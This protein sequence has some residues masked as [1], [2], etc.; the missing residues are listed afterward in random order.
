MAAPRDGAVPRPS[1]QRASDSQHRISL[2]SADAI[3]Q[4]SLPGAKPVAPSWHPHAPDELKVKDPSSSVLLPHLALQAEAWA[5]R[6]EESSASSSP[7]SP[8]ASQQIQA[9]RVLQAET[10]KLQRPSIKVRIITWNQG[11]S[12][13]KGDLGVLLGKVGEYISPEPDWDVS[14]DDGDEEAK[15]SGSADGK[16]AGSDAQSTPVSDRQGKQK[17]AIPPTQD[18]PQHK[19]R[20]R[21]MGI[22]GQE[23]VPRKD[24]IPPLPHDDAHPYHV[25][26]IAGQECPWG[27]GKRISTGM[28][29]AGE[30]GDLGR[31]K[32]RAAALAKEREKASKEGIGGGGGGAKKDDKEEQLAKEIDMADE[33]SQPHEK[34][35]PDVKTA[36]KDKAAEFPFG[37]PPSSTGLPLA[38]PGGT[39]AVAGAGWARNTRGW[40]DMCEDWLCRGPLAQATATKGMAIASTMNGPNASPLSPAL[41]DGNSPWPSR[42]PSPS[43]ISGVPSSETHSIISPGPLNASSP[44]KR[45]SLAVPRKMI[46]SISRQ[47]LDSDQRR[48]PSTVN[49]VDE[50]DP[51]DDSSALSLS[52]S[53]TDRFFTPFGQSLDAAMSGD[54]ARPQAPAVPVAPADVSSTTT[55]TP[56]ATQSPRK[57]HHRLALRIPGLS[58]SHQVTVQSDGTP[59][60]LGA[61]ELVTK[62]RCYMMYTA[63]YV[64]RG[65]LDRVRGV[66]N[67]HVKSGLLSGRV[68]NKGAVGISLKL[69]Q[70]RLLFVNAHLAAHEGRIAERIANV[71]KIKRELKVDTFLP[72]DDPRNEDN[73]LTA[74]F[75][76]A[77]WFGDLNF[78]VDISRKHADWLMMQKRYDH[79]LAF[80]QL[81]MIMKEQ[82]TVFPAFLEAP[83]TFPPTFKYDVL[84]T[85]KIKR[86]QEKRRQESTRKDETLLSSS[87]SRGNISVPAGAIPGDS[88]QALSDVDDDSSSVSSLSHIVHSSTDHTV[89]NELSD[90]SPSSYVGADSAI[91]MQDQ[92]EDEIVASN[93]AAAEGMNVHGKVIKVRKRLFNAVSNAVGAVSSKHPSD[94]KSSGKPPLSTANSFTSSLLSSVTPTSS[95]SAGK[96]NDHVEPLW[97]TRS[98]GTSASPHPLGPILTNDSNMSPSAA[99]AGRRGSVA[100]SSAGT[101]PDSLSGK[102]GSIEAS[103]IAEV[104]DESE[105]QPFDTS[106]KQRV[107]SWCDRVLWR[108]NV[109]VE[110]DENENEPP[111]V[112][113]RTRAR[114]GNAFSSAFS[115]LQTK[116]E[117]FSTH[118]HLNTPRSSLIGIE[119]GRKPGERH[120]IGSDARDVDRGGLSSAVVPDSSTQHHL[121]EPQGWRARRQM[122]RS[123]RRANTLL[124]QPPSPSFAPKGAAPKRTQSALELPTESLHVSRVPHD[125]TPTR[126]FPHTRSPSMPVTGHRR[127]FS[128]NIESSRARKNSF[129]LQEPPATASPVQ[130]KNPSR[131][132]TPKRSASVN[133]MQSSAGS[134]FGKVPTIAE[135]TTEQSLPSRTRTSANELKSP[136]DDS[137]KQPVTSSA[138]NTSRRISYWADRLGFAHLNP[139]VPS[140]VSNALRGTI[141]SGGEPPHALGVDDGTHGD[142]VAAEAAATLIGPKTGAVECLLYKSLNDREMRMLE[143]RSDHRPVIFVGSIGIGGRE[144][145]HV[146]GGTDGHLSTRLE[147]ASSGVMTAH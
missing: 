141:I 2:A 42:P 84:K 66:S 27:D 112:G 45:V 82:P 99:S 109:A 125:M 23:N 101:E 63:V 7:V 37:D 3:R 52:P 40:S 119:E 96:G 131:H 113:I 73:D 60:S 68:G 145:E 138:P 95:N 9:E 62:E 140:A 32:S 102:E 49:E 136:H 77:F 87:D 4:G 56:T 21:G 85:I 53:P 103:Q 69:G 38:T 107:P 130:Q 18:P 5:Q 111:M 36:Q 61:Y 47:R 20:Y 80:D 54:V 128:F 13:P 43:T 64:W 90:F 88:S 124:D 14:D 16:A 89:D 94:R 127:R 70:T 79:A 57:P 35:K 24:R 71:E 134:A 108:S 72:A 11:N 92:M 129:T 55:M 97:R 116:A 122:R 120:I 142:D 115:R 78:R 12:V 146:N 15:A 59:L 67:G 74:C 110:D 34:G 93:T 33:K 8:L 144:H 83:I 114:L 58:G 39:G 65:C 139:F 1:S 75:D 48:Q 126:S 76:Y 28:G 44:P 6:G 123:V 147:S 81:R 133:L 41:N 106:A 51:V 26:V 117:Q 132:P 137:S 105:T 118:H 91:N 46:R 143:G 86:A 50:H 10:V 19:K 100:T 29:L 104:Q 30:L 98:R 22:A 17:N 135:N 31:S 25:V 121:R